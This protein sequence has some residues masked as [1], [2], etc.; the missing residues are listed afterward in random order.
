MSVDK[1]LVR[2]QQIPYANWYVDTDNTRVTA[3]NFQSIL[4]YTKTNSTGYMKNSATTG[5]SWG[6][7]GNPCNVSN[8][9]IDFDG[10]AGPKPGLCLTAQ[11]GPVTLKPGT[12]GIFYFRVPNSVLTPVDSGSNADVGFYAGN[13]GAPASVVVQAK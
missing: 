3:A 7:I 1:I 11:S 2:G 6:G 13:V 10:A 12:Y 9:L 4:N 5:G 8:L